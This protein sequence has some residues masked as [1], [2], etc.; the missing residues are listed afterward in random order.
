MLSGLYIASACL[1]RFERDGA[2]KE[3]LA[4]LQ[5]SVENALYDVQQAMDG[6]WPTCPADRW[7][8]CCAS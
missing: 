7:P 1:K 6:F 2:P 5:W 8:W 3:D 4:L